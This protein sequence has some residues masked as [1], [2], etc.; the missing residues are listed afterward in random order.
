MERQAQICVI[1]GIKNS[2]KTTLIR[3]L[4]GEL[5]ARGLRTAVIKHDGHDFSCDVP[6]TDSSLFYEAGAYGTAVFSRNRMFVHRTETCRMGD[7]KEDREDTAKWEQEK[8]QELIALFPEA[9]MIFIEGLKNTPLPKIEV[10]RAGFL[11]KPV[12][13]PKGR[14]LI[15]TD[16]PA[17]SFDEKVLGPGQV[18]EIADEILKNAAASDVG[19]DSTQ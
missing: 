12:S 8:A 15:V 18:S 16:L 2:G 3:A 19:S 17:E 6:G 7:K 10:V 14:F 1:C 11:T 9:D 4:I 5:T 13:N